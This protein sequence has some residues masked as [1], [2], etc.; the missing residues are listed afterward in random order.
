MGHE[1]ASECK[2]AQARRRCDVWWKVT[3]AIALTLAILVAGGLAW[4]G[5]YRP[6]SIEAPQGVQLSPLRTVTALE[7]RI[8]LMM[9]GVH[10]IPVSN[11]VDLY[12]MNYTAQT[13]KGAMRLSGLLALPHVGSARRLVSF[14]HG[15]ATTRS[16][17][18]SRPDGTGIAAAIAFAGNGYALIAPDYPGMGDAEGRHPYYVGDAIGPSIVA[19]IEA[20]QQLDDVPD[21]P[22][23]LAGFSEGAWASLV[24]LRLIENA[25]GRVLGSAQVA[26]P[27]DLRHLS[28]PTTLRE[29]GPSGS[30]YLA[31]AAWGQA[32][33]FG[34]PLDSALDRKYTALVER[35]FAGAP[36]EEIV[37]S[38]PKQPREMFVR[39][40][41]DA[42]NGHGAHWLAD[43]FAQ[44]S[45]I[46]LTPRAPVRLYY[47]AK[48]VDVPPQESIS[49]AA[50]MTERGADVAAIDVG[51]HPHDASMLAAA[52]LILAWL[53]ELETE[54]KQ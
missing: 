23:F 50:R 13:P 12:R 17:V 51:P 53:N 19:M 26:G 49:A 44:N 43:S 11:A 34:K 30:L 39:A 37:A 54:S 9:T 35:L 18:P 7:A 24:A 38:L 8:L 22:V 15:T 2:T 16:A 3:L 33:Y 25:G 48:D 42:M 41:L 20:A 40:F 45:L 1:Q 46:D 47:G 5:S 6:R 10:G 52:P 14:Q 27:Y 21:A 32:A 36:P 28:V 4:L 31:Y 29:P